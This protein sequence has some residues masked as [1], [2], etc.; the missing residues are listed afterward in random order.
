M[1]IGGVSKRVS[2]SDINSARR[3]EASRPSTAIPIIGRMFEFLYFQ[4]VRPRVESSDADAVCFK[5]ASPR[6]RE[7]GRVG[8]SAR[9]PCEVV[10]VPR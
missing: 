4:I 9:R 6:V 10:N 8:V 5:L 1:Y 7:V 3:C 2:L